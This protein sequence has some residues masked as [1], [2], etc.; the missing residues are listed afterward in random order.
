[1]DHRSNSFDTDPILIN[2]TAAANLT[3]VVMKNIL[4]SN[5]MR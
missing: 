3:C 2:D 4:C 5:I 1:M